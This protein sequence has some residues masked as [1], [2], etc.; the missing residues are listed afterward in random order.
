MKKYLVV[1]N[2][3]R[4]GNRMSEYATMFTL[5]KLYNVTS[6]M[7]THQQ[8][9][10]NKIFPNLSLIPYLNNTNCWFNKTCETCERNSKSY[11]DIKAIDFENCKNIFVDHY[12]MAPKLFHN[13]RNK[14]LEKEFLLSQKIK[15]EVKKYISS[16]KIKHFGH[17]NDHIQVVG[18]HVR[19]GDFQDYLQKN[20]IHGGYFLSKMYFSRAIKYFK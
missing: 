7:S 1:K 14:L 8:L 3:G 4:L 13:L 19:R 11:K 2:P 10:L 18:I 16:I 15:F 17:S 6:A 9:F 20:K 12:P 5:N